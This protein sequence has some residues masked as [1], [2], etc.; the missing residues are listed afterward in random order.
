MYTNRTLLHIDFTCTNHYT[1]HLSIFFIHVYLRRKDVPSF[2]IIALVIK[3]KNRI[4]TSGNRHIVI[5]IH[6]INIYVIKIIS[7]HI[8]LVKLC[9]F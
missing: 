9:N 3:I 1:Y 4:I 2:Y 8:F 7:I 6:M 5:A